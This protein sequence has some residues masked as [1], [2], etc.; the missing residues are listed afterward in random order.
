MGNYL[1]EPVKDKHS[2]TGKGDSHDWGC[3][4]MQGWRVSMEDAVVTRSDL[5]Q[6]LRGTAMFA[7]FDGHG[8]KEVAKFCEKHM[9]SVLLEES[10]RQPDHLNDALENAFHRV[11]DMLRSEA[12]QHELI[13]LKGS[14]DGGSSSSSSGVPVARSSVAIKDSLKQDIV[15]AKSK[16]GLSKEDAK[17]MMMKMMLLKRMD[18]ADPNDPICGP[19]DQ[20]GCTAVCVLLTATEIICANAGDSRAV[21]CRKGRAVPL[22]EDHKPNDPAERRRIEEAGGTVEKIERGVMTTYRVNGNLSLSRAIGDLQYKSRKDL[23]PHKQVVCA[24]PDLHRES[25]T[26]QDEFI[27]LAC[28]GIWDVKSSQ[29]VCSFI[30]RRLI[31][32]I[33][34]SMAIEQLLDS[35]CTPDPKKTQGLGA[36]NMSCIVVQLKRWT[37][38]VDGDT[39]CGCSAS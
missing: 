26:P 27:V 17:N 35:C 22:S 33:P 28:D 29:E 37:M 2:S 6:H 13:Q 8:G 18:D 5:G 36:D 10:G 14:N 34:I 20:V 32:K 24:T 16:G 3:S 19:A 21:L 25:I 4:H 9:P 12:H 11:D 38:Q 23:P 39:S 15:Q 7:V 1:S 30:R 31:N